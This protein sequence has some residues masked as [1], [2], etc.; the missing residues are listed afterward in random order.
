MCCKKYEEVLRGMKKNV[1]LH[2][3]F[4][5]YQMAAVVQLVEQR[6]VVP[7]VVGS[8]PINRPR[9][10][11]VVKSANDESCLPIFYPFALVYCNVQ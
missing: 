8:S 7:C 2:R 5:T 1:F 6:I 11:K 4:E 3:L 9:D 10:F